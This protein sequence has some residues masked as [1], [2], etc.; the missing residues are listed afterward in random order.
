MFEG[1]QPKNQEMREFDDLQKKRLG[2]YVYALRDPR[3]EKLFYVG[4]GERDRV[5]SHFKEA[6]NAL[7]GG[8]VL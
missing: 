3:D 4:Q 6:E 7:N 8:K 5:L 2:L 1:V